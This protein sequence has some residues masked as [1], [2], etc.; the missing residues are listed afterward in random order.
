M[1][2]TTA[3]KNDNGGFKQAGFDTLMEDKY[4]KATDLKNT[5]INQITEQIVPQ[6]TAS[7]IQN[8]KTVGGD[9]TSIDSEIEL[10]KNVS[11]MFGEGSIPGYKS[12]KLTKLVQYG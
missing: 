2:K 12:N 4:K 1:D 8:P 5:Y 10:K 6:D 9:G 11:P 7:S 3:R